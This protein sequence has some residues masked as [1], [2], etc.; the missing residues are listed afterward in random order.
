M[1]RNE[2]DKS[3][4]PKRQNLYHNLDDVDEEESQ[5]QRAIALCFLGLSIF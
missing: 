1:L 5:S 3:Q 2:G 4:A